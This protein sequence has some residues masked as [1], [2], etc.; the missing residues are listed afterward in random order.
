ME[1]PWGAWQ[2]DQ[3]TLVVGRQ[4]EKD[5]A[6]GK[7][8]DAPVRKPAAEQEWMDPRRLK[9]VETVKIKPNGTW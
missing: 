7:P 6:D 8:L 9:Q 5:I 2:V 1:T 4:A 3:T